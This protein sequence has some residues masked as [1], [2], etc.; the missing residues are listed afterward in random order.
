[1]LRLI[2]LATEY[3]HPLLHSFPTRRSSDLVATR[4][5]TLDATPRGDQRLDRT[6]GGLRPG[7]GRPRNGHGERDLLRGLGTTHPSPGRGTRLRRIPLVLR[8]SPPRGRG[9]GHRALQLPPDPVDQIRGPRTRT[10]Q[11]GRAQARSTYRRLRW[12]RVAADLRGSGT[13]RR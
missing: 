5:R 2:S 6:R 7:E 4:G 12:G 11:R 3:H 10:G 9:L 13:S 8:P 1:L